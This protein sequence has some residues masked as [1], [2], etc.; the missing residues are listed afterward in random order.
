MEEAGR[1]DLAR[2]KKG[3]GAVGKN[4]QARYHT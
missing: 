3:T 1:S 4:E 2:G